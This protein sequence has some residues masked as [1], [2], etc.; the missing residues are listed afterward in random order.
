MKTAATAAPVVITIAAGVARPR[1][2]GRTIASAA[3]I[4]SPLPDGAKGLTRHHRG[5]PA[6]ERTG[7]DPYGFLMVI[8]TSRPRI[9]TISNRK[10]RWSIILDL[11]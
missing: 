3:T 7:P 8:L 5:G 4:M 11:Q 1:A 2:R 10:R 9:T 6:R